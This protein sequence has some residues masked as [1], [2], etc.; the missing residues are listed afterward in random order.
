MM[1]KE[2]KK[3]SLEVL[4]VRE[5]MLGSSGKYTD[6]AFG[7]HTPIDDITFES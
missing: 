2:W 6:A 5:T 1:K 7:S 4:S 3:P